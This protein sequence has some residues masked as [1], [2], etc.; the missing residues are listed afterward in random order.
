MEILGEGGMG[1]VYKARHKLT[2]E[3]VALKCVL[4]V[5]TM[6][7]EY[8]RR[9]A[10]E[11]QLLHR[12]RHPHVVQL[13]SSG[14]H[15]GQPWLALELLDGRDLRDRM[16]EETLSARE[17]LMI[18]I[19]IAEALSYTHGQ[20][21]IHRDLKPENVLLDA[22]GSAKVTDFGLASLQAPTKSAPRLTQAGVAMGTVDYMAPEQMLDA[23]ACGPPADLYSLGVLTYELFAG[24][25]PYGAEHICSVVSGIPGELDDLIYSM[26]QK[27]P[28]RRPASAA[29]VVEHLT[30]ILDIIDGGNSRGA[31]VMKASAGV[32]PPAGRTRSKS[33]APPPLTLDAVGGQATP[34]SMEPV[35]DPVQAPPTEKPMPAGLELGKQSPQREA[36][37]QAASPPQSPQPRPGPASTQPVPVS[38]QSGPASGGVPAWAIGLVAVL[39]LGGGMIA[40]R[41]GVARPASDTPSAATTKAPAA[42]PAP[43]AT[44]GGIRLQTQPSGAHI[45]VD[46][47]DTGK[48]TP[49]TIDGLAPGFHKFDL[50]LA[51][52][53]DKSAMYKVV[54]GRT[55]TAEPQLEKTGRR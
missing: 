30:Q 36:P 5:H 19:E 50:K 2:G 47:N 6:E 37:R 42:P 27:E 51:G 3:L 52:Y 28:S 14:V 41:G 7:P 31:P 49:D 32:G 34:L 46:G 4:G 9:F 23:A 16:D 45:F 8:A 26:L 40:F 22:S 11:V 55:L 10:R 38:Q 29:V 44:T 25:K 12:L 13:I 54:V 18:L 1:A 33:V 24:D 15:K 39:I 43:V 17:K 21:V 35:S 53:S 20:Q 48:V